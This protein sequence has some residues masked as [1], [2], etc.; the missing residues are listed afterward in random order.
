MMLNPVLPQR[1]TDRGGAGTRLPSIRLQLELF[2]KTF[3]KPSFLS[4][5]LVGE[6]AL[7]KKLAD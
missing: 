3:F 5:T 1:R 6:F 7:F 2:V 4:F